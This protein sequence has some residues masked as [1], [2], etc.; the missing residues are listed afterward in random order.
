MN[1]RIAYL[2]T[3]TGDIALPSSYLS[4]Y[5]RNGTRT[6]NRATLG[7]VPP[8]SHGAKRRKLQDETVFFPTSGDKCLSK[9]LVKKTSTPP[10]KRPR[11]SGPLGDDEKRIQCMSNTFF[12]VLIANNVYSI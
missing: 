7:Y 3:A 9:T 10:L 2:V 1:L 8:H 12:T 6:S 4:V 5:R 11:S